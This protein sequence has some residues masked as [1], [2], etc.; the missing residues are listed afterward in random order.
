MTAPQLQH[1]G[2]EPMESKMSPVA[3]PKR[4]WVVGWVIT[5]LGF[6]LGGLLVTLV[7]GPL[8]TPVQGILGG[9]LAGLVIGAAE[10]L[11]LRRRLPLAPLWIAATAAGMAIGVGLS[12]ALFGAEN[13]MTAIL[14]RAVVS[15]LALGLAQW[16]ILRAYVRLAILWPL[17]VMIAFVVAWFITA[18]VIGDNRSLGFVVFGSSGAVTFQAL[19]GLALWG[20]LKSDSRAA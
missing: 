2:S 16:L 11:A 18:Q 17:A 4:N 5:F 13:T 20:L 14:T 12:M 1:I 19:T 6:P 8:T 10:W 3:L 7:I 9:A 15:G